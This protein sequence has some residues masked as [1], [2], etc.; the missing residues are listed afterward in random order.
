MSRRKTSFDELSIGKCLVHNVSH[1]RR[2][3][4]PT[5][6]KNDHARMYS[7][8]VPS[9]IRHSIQSQEAKRIISNPPC[10]AGNAEKDRNE[11]SVLKRK[12]QMMPSHDSYPVLSMGISTKPPCLKTP[13]VMLLK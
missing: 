9:Q 7:C 11:P 5:T 10:A 13:L 6:Q 3:V 1:E 4:V 8:F 2:K 12:R